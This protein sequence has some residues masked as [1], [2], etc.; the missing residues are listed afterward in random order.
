MNVNQLLYLKN[1]SFASAMFRHQMHNLQRQQR[2]EQEHGCARSTGPFSNDFPNKKFK[3]RI[4]SGI[5]MRKTLNRIN[6]ISSW[7]IRA[8]S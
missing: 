2:I 3:P 4:T 1:N 7:T 6:P 8:Q 5:D